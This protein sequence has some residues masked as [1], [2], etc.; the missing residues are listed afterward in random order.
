M[1]TLI[2]VIKTIIAIPRTAC[3]LNVV[4]HHFEYFAYINPSALTNTLCREP[5]T[6]QMRKRRH[7]KVRSVVQR[8]RVRA[9]TQACGSRA[10]TLL[11]LNSPLK[12]MVA[13]CCRSL[14]SV[15]ATTLC[16]GPNLSPVLSANWLCSLESSL[17]DTPL[18]QKDVMA[19]RGVIHPLFSPST[20]FP[21]ATEPAAH[22]LPSS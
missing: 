9:Q 7:R 5:S 2:I 11:L 6:S 8:G 10:H 15:T 12:F 14:L 16:S 18:S 19:L 1:S 17:T 3:V 21:P 13:S 4:R 20:E 22:W